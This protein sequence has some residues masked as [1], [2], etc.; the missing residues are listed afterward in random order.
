MKALTRFLAAAVLTFLA[1]VAAAQGRVFSQ[2]E[3]D[4]A[5]AP[6]ALYPDNL[7]SQILMASTYPQQVAEAASLARVN[8]NLRGEEAVRAVE[9][10]T[11]DPSVISLA[12]FP[13]VLI[14]MDER[15]EWTASLGEM[16][17]GQP[18]Q[19][20]DTI[21]ALRGRA[22][23]AGNLRTSEEMTVQR[24]ARDYVLESP[25][26]VAYVPY[27][28][29][30]TVYGNW[31]W[32]SYPPVY[33][34][35]WP[36]Y[37]WGL[38]YAFGWGPPV[39]VSYGYYYG[40]FNWRHRYQH[41]YNHKPWYANGHGHGNYRPGDR[42]THNGNRQYAGGQRG[43]WNGDRRGAWNGDRRGAGNG[44]NG[45]HWNGGPSAPRYRTD[46][47]GR[48]NPTNNAGFFR[49]EASPNA[50]R[51]ARPSNP[52][53]AAPQIANPV[54]RQMEARTFNGPRAAQMPGAQ[55]THSRPVYRQPQGSAPAPQRAVPQGGGVQRQAN[56]IA[57]SAP[58]SGGNHGGGGHRGNGGGNGGGSRG[59][60]GGGGH[61]GRGN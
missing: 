11:W 35:P 61:H 14:M 1:T 10:A 17:L 3:L 52:A 9:G 47:N 50:N 19:V 24:E 2:A 34:A 48:G 15:R 58:A 30:R 21:Q 49:P 32:D 6:I 37:A 53:P 59:G 31:W 46:G 57:R 60:G 23:A 38:G 20:M 54:Q 28:D 27:Y 5:L 44:G 45:G 41:Y 36:G 22:D 43:N 7:L 25:P 18:G 42:W 16:N 51:L 33:W 40:G 12:A 29:P 13:E 56:P 26:E 4:Q 55:A 8:R 39:Y